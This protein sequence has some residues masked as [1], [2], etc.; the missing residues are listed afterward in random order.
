MRSILMHCFIL[1]LLMLIRV[2]VAFAHKVMIFAWVQGDRVYTESK[3]SGGRKAVNA[4]VEVLNAAGEKLLEGITDDSGAFSFRVP[5]KTEMKVV[6]LAG[7]GHRAEW[8][9]PVKAFQDSVIRGEEKPD[10]KKLPEPQPREPAV[11]A[12]PDDDS[13]GRCLAKE[14]I[15][16]IVEE[17]LQK[18]LAPM[19]ASLK[20]PENPNQ[21]PTLTDIL[22]GLGYILGLVGVGM[23]FNY[24]RK[25]DK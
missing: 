15:E 20:R 8:T 16:A 17:T 1:S 9:I 13:R 21:G 24:R 25:N 5:E 10:L 12:H 2:H 4:R 7:T 14:D 23:Y 6:L 3:F 11:S 22:S 19:A 18:E